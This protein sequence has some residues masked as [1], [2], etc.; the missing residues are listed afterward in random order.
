MAEEAQC[1]HC[2]E[3]V[4]I[5]APYCP[6]CGYR[7]HRVPSLDQSGN[8]PE[9]N[10]GLIAMM[11]FVGPLASCGSCALF[12]GDNLMFPLAMLAL[13]GGFFVIGLIMVLANVIKA[14]SRKRR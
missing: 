14:L 10:W 13:G 1:P 11:L 12:T 8:S 9:F 3:S 6:D 5:G 2:G 4:A 7:L